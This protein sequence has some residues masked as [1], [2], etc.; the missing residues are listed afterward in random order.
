MRDK[1]LGFHVSP[2]RRVSICRLLEPYSQQASGAPQM[3]TTHTQL[4][5]LFFS[6]LGNRPRAWDHVSDPHSLAASIFRGR[7]LPDFGLD[8]TGWP[9]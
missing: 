3:Q 9:R 8:R 5:F 4:P 6:L 7:R 1:A 2:S